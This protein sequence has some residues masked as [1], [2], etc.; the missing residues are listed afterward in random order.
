M[1]N[2]NNGTEKGRGRT[3]GWTETGKKRDTWAKLSPSPDR[4]RERAGGDFWVKNKTEEVGRNMQD[5]EEVGGGGQS[6][7]FQAEEG[8]RFKAR[9]GGRE[10]E[11]RERDAIR[12][13]RS[14]PKRTASL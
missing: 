2:N 4:S 14:S 6:K 1:I 8:E 5:G 10:G 12:P 9:E 13:R 7:E 3:N 11:E